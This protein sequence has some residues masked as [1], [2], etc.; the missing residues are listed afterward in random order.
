MLQKCLEIVVKI[1]CNRSFANF[2]LVTW[3][4]IKKIG[5]RKIFVSTIKICHEEQ[6]SQYFWFLVSNRDMPTWGP[7]CHCCPDYARSPGNQAWLTQIS[8]ARAWQSS[9]PAWEP[10]GWGGP[11]QTLGNPPLPADIASLGVGHVHLGSK[12]RKLKTLKLE[13]VRWHSMTATEGW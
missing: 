5:D 11:G 1:I 8:Q 6:N 12:S 13:W 4:L 7:G 3:I 2:F 9:L 10:S